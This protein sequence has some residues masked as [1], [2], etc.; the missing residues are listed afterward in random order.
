MSAYAPQRIYSFASSLRDPLTQPTRIYCDG[1]LQ[2]VSYSDRP[3]VP[4]S[5][6]PGFHE[7]VVT[8]DA[9]RADVRASCQQAGALLEIDWAQF[10]DVQM[11]GQPEAWSGLKS[12]RLRGPGA[13]AMFEIPADFRFQA[14]T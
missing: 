5:P 11:P 9:F 8:R 10:R 7:Y 14:Q 12:M 1:V 6:A 3:V 2:V 13:T 4:L